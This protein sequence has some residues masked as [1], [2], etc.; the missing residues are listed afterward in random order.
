MNALSETVDSLKGASETLLIPLACRARASRENI[1]SG[2]T[3]R[4]AEEICDHFS[5][6]LD[7]YASDLPTLRGAV[8]RG[9]WFDKRVLAFLK[10]R[11]DALILSIGSGLNTMYERVAAQTGPLAGSGPGAGWRWID[12][13]LADVVAL[14]NTVFDDAPNRATIEIDASSTAWLQDPQLSGPAP[15]LVIS[16]AVLIYLPEAQVAAAFKGIAEIGAER[17]DCGFLFDWCSPEMVKRSRSHPAM[18][19]LKDQSVVFRSSMRR[20]ADIR[21]YHPDWRILEEASTPMTRSGAAPALFYF[22]FKLTTGRRLYGL[23]E[24][25]LKTNRQ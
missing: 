13:D 2:F 10:K 24:A 5:V 18:K 1:V 9:L 19:K 16:E 11:P 23:A 14:R 8:H 4:K 3:D 7:R 21:N 22:L 20:A 25:S 15:L 17:P 6:D 12:S